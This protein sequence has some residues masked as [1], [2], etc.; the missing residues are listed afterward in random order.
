MEFFLLDTLK[1]TF[2]NAEFNP[3]I[4]R[5]RVFLSKIREFFSIFQSCR[6]GLLSPP[7]WTPVSV[8]KCASIF[9]KML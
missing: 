2:L 6:R 3:K 5:I 7:S 9:L 4:D 1:T 8:A